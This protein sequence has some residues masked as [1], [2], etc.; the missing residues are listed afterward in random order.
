MTCENRRVPKY[1][2]TSNAQLHV[3]SKMN[4]ALPTTLLADAVLLIHFAVVLFIVGGL[5][6][7]VAGNLLAWRW[8]NTLGF[9]VAHLAA[10][11]F[12]V[13]ESWLGV[14]CPLTSLESWLRTQAGSAAYSEGF[15]EHW[16]QRLLFYEAPPWVF[17]AVYTLFGLLVVAAWWRYPP[18][19]GQP[20]H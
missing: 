6:L 19:H 7:V 9:R 2:S 15:I 14:V 8:V 20:R 12:V 1:I 4:P 16:I 18:R 11:G 3:T 5:V 17:I 10:I 13:A